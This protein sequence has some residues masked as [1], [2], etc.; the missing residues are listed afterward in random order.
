MRGRTEAVNMRASRRECCSPER[1]VDRSRPGPHVIFRF[2]YAYL[3]SQFSAFPTC[4]SLRAPMKL[5][6]LAA[7]PVIGLLLSFSITPGV[8]AQCGMRGEGSER[9]SGIVFDDLNQDGQHGSSESGVARV[10]V[11]NGCEVVLTDSDGLYEI[12]LAPGQILFVSQPSGYV[13]P[14]DECVM[15]CEP[16]P[17]W[18]KPTG[19][20]LTLATPFQRRQ[21]QHTSGNS[22]CR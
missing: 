1:H 19:S 17:S 10:S 15:W 9:V 22:T 11:S 2:G 4:M 13:V 18:K 5:H 14:V 6:A 21:P 3:D 8:Q 12:S 20:L 16:T 7:S